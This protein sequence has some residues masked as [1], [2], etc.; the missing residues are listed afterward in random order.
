MG[1]VEEV[2]GGGGGGGGMTAY[3]NEG[4]N[5]VCVLHTYMEGMRE[6]GGGGAHII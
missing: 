1:R 5:V 4:E 6:G 3:M 2:G